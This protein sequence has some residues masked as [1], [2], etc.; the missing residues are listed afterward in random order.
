MINFFLK[1][2]KMN[3]NT[4]YAQVGDTDT[5]H[6]Y[7]GRPEDFPKTGKRTAIALTPQRPGIIYQPYEYRYCVIIKF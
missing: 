3:V 1:A 2:S 6:S 4:V 7:W 5:D